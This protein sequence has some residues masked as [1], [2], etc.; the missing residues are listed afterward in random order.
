M[1]K[2]FLYSKIKIEYCRHV[3]HSPWSCHIF[4]KKKEKKKEEEEKKRRV[5]PKTL[6]IL[7]LIRLNYVSLKSFEVILPS[8]HAHVHQ[9]WTPIQTVLGVIG[10]QYG[11]AQ[12]TGDCHIPACTPL[13][14]SN[15]QRLGLCMRCLGLCCLGFDIVML[16]VC[17]RFQNNYNGRNWQYKIKIVEGI[18]YHLE[19][20]PCFC[21]CC[22]FLFFGWLDLVLDSNTLNIDGFQFL[23]YF[24]TILLFQ[25]EQEG[26]VLSTGIFCLSIGARRVCFEYRH[27][28]SLNWSKKGMFWIQ[29]LFVSQL[30]QEGYVLSTGIFVSQLEQEGYVLSTGIFVS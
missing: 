24:I 6:L 14:W 27:F 3:T 19:I 5:M 20:L 18:L 2:T 12:S 28:L 4:E 10:S 22:S 8:Q 30:E 21:F 29:A 11:N 25:L 16:P 23:C 1:D 17:C 15:Y 13:H 7:A 26:Y 9:Q